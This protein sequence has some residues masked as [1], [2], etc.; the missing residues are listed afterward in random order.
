M[1]RFPLL[2]TAGL[3]LAAISGRSEGDCGRHAADPAHRA[4]FLQKCGVSSQSLALVRQVHGTAVA[5]ADTCG[6]ETADG[7]V[8]DLGEADGIIT[9]QPDIVLGIAVA[10]CVPVWLYDPRTHSGGLLHA[11][12]EGTV[13][14]ICR[15]G[16]RLLGECYGAEPGNIL[17]VVGPS[18]GPC[19]YEVSQEM[20]ARLREGG[21]PLSGRHLDLWRANREILEKSG[22]N[23]HNIHV[24]AHC[25][26]CGGRF[27]SFR[28][29]GGKERNLAVLRLGRSPEFTGYL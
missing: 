27:Y 6:P 21:F 26:I 10:D 28:K 20:A 29:D 8:V 23:S 2:E 24:M 13:S 18:A 22:L 17:A 3:E 9:R 25:T 15:E 5:V 12:R 7:I 19:C 11:G 4:V 16:V 14:G 1:M